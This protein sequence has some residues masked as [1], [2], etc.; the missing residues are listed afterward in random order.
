MNPNTKSRNPE[1]VL[2]D[3]HQAMIHKSAED[4]AALFADQA[5]YVFP[6]LTPG[7]PAL[8]RNREEILTGFKI[9]LCCESVGEF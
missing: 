1:E 4:F 2:N 6:F 7:R 3:F 5:H 8:Y 9:G